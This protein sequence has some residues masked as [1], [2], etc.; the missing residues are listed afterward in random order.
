MALTIDDQAAFAK[1]SR[2]LLED[3]DLSAAPEE[4]DEPPEAGGEDEQGE[5]GG[6]EDGDDEG[7][8][9]AQR[10]DAEMRAEQVEEEGEGDTSP[11]RWSSATTSWPT[12]TRASED[13]RSPRRLAA[14][15]ICRRRP[16]TRRSPPA[17]TRWSRRTSY[18]T[19]KSSARLRAYLDQQMAGLHNVVTRL[20]NRLQ[21]RLMAQQA[22]SWDFDQEEGLLDAARLAR[23]VVN[24]THS[25]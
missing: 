7:E 21:R 3:L 25:L 23:V 2:R 11:R 13:A 20:A 24:P 8:S 12:V 9:G 5:D 15:G 4:S 22:R 14:T 18:A 16:T 6:D 17:S 19:R 1:L 10:G